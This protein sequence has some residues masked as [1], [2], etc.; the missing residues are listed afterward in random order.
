V[1][2]KHVIE[3][4]RIKDLTSV[5]F[6]LRKPGSSGVEWL[7]ITLS[8]QDVRE[9]LHVNPNP[10]VDIAVLDVM[11]LINAEINKLTPQTGGA[12]QP[13]ADQPSFTIEKNGEIQTVPLS[14]YY[15]VTEDN[16]PTK[17][18]IKVSA[19]DDIVVIG[20]PERF[21]DR[22]NKP[23]ILKS[24]LLVLLQFGRFNQSPSTFR[25]KVERSVSRAP[26]RCDTRY[27]SR[28]LPLQLKLATRFLLNGT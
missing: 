24:G 2:A 20:Y 19:G 27:L 18:K 15:A 7:P 4:L 23:P 12:N 13:T 14:P 8:A 17:S 10:A 9:R 6:F 26:Y 25:H 28:F 3:P 5:K 1:T 11:D 16:F 22:Y 21:F